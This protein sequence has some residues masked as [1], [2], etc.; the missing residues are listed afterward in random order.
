MA[1]GPGKNRELRRKDKGESSSSALR[2]K[3][4]PAGSAAEDANSALRPGQRFLEGAG[5]SAAQCLFVRGVFRDD[6]LGGLPAVL[7][8]SRGQGLR[9]SAG[10]GGKQTANKGNG[11]EAGP[12]NWLQRRGRR[13]EQRSGPSPE[14]S[15]RR[16]AFGGRQKTRPKP[17]KSGKYCDFF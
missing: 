13:G 10:A 2:S 9:R 15:R 1:L 12:T 17:P 14:A 8:E 16:A 6:S 11:R 4:K 7:P 3:G 5:R